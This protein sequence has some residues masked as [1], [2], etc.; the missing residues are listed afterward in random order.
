MDQQQRSSTRICE[1]CGHILPGSYKESLCRTCKEEALYKQ[2]KEYIQNHSVTE[3]EV[4][5]H[6]QLPLST[7]RRWVADG[8]I[9]YRANDS[10]W[11]ETNEKYFN[12]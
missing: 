4:A 6:F 5:Q 10:T 8:R 12:V 11:D 9:E 7:I 2:V 1:K 3:F